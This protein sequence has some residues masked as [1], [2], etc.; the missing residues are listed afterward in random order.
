VELIVEA[1]KTALE[2]PQAKKQFGLAQEYNIAS[3][4][5]K[6]YVLFGESCGVGIM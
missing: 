3:L 4:S 6:G 5:Q 2:A 1:D